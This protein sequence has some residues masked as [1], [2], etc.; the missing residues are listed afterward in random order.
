MDWSAAVAG[1][2]TSSPDPPLPPLAKGGRS[3]RSFERFRVQDEHVSKRMRNEQE[4]SNS[5]NL[6]F[7]RHE[8]GE[9]EGLK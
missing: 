9:Q 4:R 8:A 6:G 1:R 3:H 5:G 2:G 7:F